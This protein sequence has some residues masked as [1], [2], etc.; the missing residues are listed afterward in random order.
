ML[1]FLHMDKLE[2]VKLILLLVYILLQIVIRIYLI[3]Y[4]VNNEVYYPGH[5]KA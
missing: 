2:Q 3:F 4:Q 5:F 1:L